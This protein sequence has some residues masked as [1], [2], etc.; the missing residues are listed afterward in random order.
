[1]ILQQNES[2]MFRSSKSFVLFALIAAMT[3]TGMLPAM[4]DCNM[5]GNGCGAEQCCGACCNES[6]TTAH[7][8]LFDAHRARYLQLFC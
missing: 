3:F 1:M 7:S 8:W 2:V 4:A 6:D 5:Q